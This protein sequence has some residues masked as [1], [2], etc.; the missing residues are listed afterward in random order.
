MISK[1]L[2]KKYEMLELKDYEEIYGTSK[3]T[4]LTFYD[5]FLKATDYLAIKLA[6]GLISKEDKAEEFEARQFCRDEINRLE[7]EENK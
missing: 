4:K 3:E 2:L 1:E 7:S 6:E 5:T